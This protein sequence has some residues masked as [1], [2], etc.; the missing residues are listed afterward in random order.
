MFLLNDVSQLFDQFSNKVYNPQFTDKKTVELVALACSVMADCPP[1]IEW[2]YQQAVN[3]GAGRDEISE[4][5]AVAMSISAGSKR[6]KYGA[7]I[8]GLEQKN[9]SA[10]VKAEG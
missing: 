2:H 4:V 5:L 1:C 10:V 9:E 7:L 6:A 8:A 3:A